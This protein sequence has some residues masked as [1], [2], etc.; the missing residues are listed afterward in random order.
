M[1]GCEPDDGAVQARLVDRFLCAAGEQLPTQ[2]ASHLADQE[3]GYCGPFLVYSWT[4]RVT[5]SAG[6]RQSAFNTSAG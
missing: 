6:V 3:N 1:S 4:T 5:G 2:Q